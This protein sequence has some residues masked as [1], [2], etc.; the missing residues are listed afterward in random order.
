MTR[1]RASPA[2]RGLLAARA[3]PQAPR[4][5]F[6]LLGKRWRQSLQLRVVASTLALSAAVV[7]VLGMILQNEITQRLLSTK[8][9]AAVTQVGYALNALQP[10]LDGITGRTGREE[11]SS[12]L[13]NALSK[14]TSTSPSEQNTGNSEAGPYQAVLVRGSVNQPASAT[15][16]TG[17]YD[18]VPSALS[19]LVIKGSRAT[20]ITTV[21]IGQGRT[22]YLVVGTAVH[23]APV[24]LQLYLM[25]PLS[26]EQHTVS[27]VQNTIAVGGLLLVLLLA[28]IAKLVTGQ[29]TKPVK[30]AAEVADRF[31]AG[32]R[33]ERMRVVGHD[34]LARLGEAY[35]EMAENITEQIRQLE[36][37]GELQRRFTSDVSHELRTPLTTVR[38]AADVLHASS[39]QFPS[40]LSRSTELLVAELD[41]FEALLNDLLEISRLDAGVEELALERVDLRD[42]TTS[43]VAYVHGIADQTATELRLELGE[44]AATAPIDPRRVERVLRNLLGNAI[45]HGE[46]KP[47]RVVIGVDEQAV[48]VCVRDYGVGLRS[49]EAELVFNRFWRADASRNRRTGGT[50]LG[51]AIGTEDARLHGG[52]LEA[53]GEPGEG[54]CFRLTLPRERGATPS[55]SPLPL[56]PAATEGDGPP[57]A[58]GDKGDGDRAAGQAVAVLDSPGA[59]T[60][61]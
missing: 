56:P 22:T 58:A 43:A 26:S 40:G 17:P 46:G 10:A 41:R 60:P 36:E 48:A 45:D 8:E 35:N 25:F 53:W 42:V 2:R 61:T 16:S 52:R 38:M 57:A 9:K 5:W 37:F 49:G 39:E 14:L 30:Q 18:A 33:D 21:D 4:R 47:V 6:Q 51:L 1:L 50:G 29:V 31:A 7:F 55:S 20:Q 12:Q 27:I 32:H 19:E 44:V 15:P 59:G 23:N 3:L 28:G 13:A 54:A 11:T 34:E 24:P